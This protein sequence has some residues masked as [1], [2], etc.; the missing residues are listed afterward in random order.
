MQLV[1][2]KAKQRFINIFDGTSRRSVLQ[3]TNA[4]Y[5]YDY[6]DDDY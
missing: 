2:N 5:D 1:A 4:M 6:D 3:F